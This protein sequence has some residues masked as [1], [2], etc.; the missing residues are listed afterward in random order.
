MRAIYT[1]RGA[2]REYAPLAVNLFTGCG[3]G[4]LYCYAAELDL[5]RGRTASKE[6]WHAMVR[7]RPGIIQALERDAKALANRQGLFDPPPGPVLLC[8]T[9][10]PYQLDAALNHV[11][12]QALEIL[13][14]AGLGVKLL[15]KAG[16]A[17][18][19]NL[20]LLSRYARRHWFGQSFTTLDPELARVWEPNAAPP[21]ERLAALELARRAGLRTWVS[22]E[23]VLYP[24]RMVELVRE[25]APVV[26]SFSVGILNPKTS[27]PP[28]LPDRALEGLG[29]GLPLMRRRLQ[30]ELERLGYERVID[31]AVLSHEGKTYYFKNALRMGAWG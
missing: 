29:A 7:A 3:H 25:L 15:S 22:L 2:A 23:P 10:D 14:G 31:G 28:D 27:L 1:P 26:D 9:C 8:F 12:W 19:R 16:R 21:A 6:A 5:K 4:C 11:T 24:G 18:C 20:E 30:E 17:A 13:T